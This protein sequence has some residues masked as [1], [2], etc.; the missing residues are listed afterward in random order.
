M[1]VNVSQI[2]RLQFTGFVGSALRT[3]RTAKMLAW[4]VH[5]CGAPW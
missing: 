3:V 5:R 2:F 1:L 4:I